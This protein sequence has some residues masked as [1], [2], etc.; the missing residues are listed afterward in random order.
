MQAFGGVAYLDKAGED[1][2]EGR[3]DA[4]RGPDGG[5]QGLSAAG[6]EGEGLRYDCD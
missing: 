5:N 6:E 1:G 3:V 2:E 4:G